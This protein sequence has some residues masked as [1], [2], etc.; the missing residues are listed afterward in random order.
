[1]LEL[2][3]AQKGMVATPRREQADLVVLNTCTVTAAAD[4]D[5]RQTLRRVH[6]E[7]EAAR[8]LVTGCYAQ[9]AP[10]ELAALPGVTWVVGNSHKHQAAEIATASLFESSAGSSSGFVPIAQLSRDRTP[11]PP[12]PKERERLGRSAN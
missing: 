5:V 11:V 12:F 4:D 7:N 10:D 6:R 2:L 9:R 8:I 3:L 1:A